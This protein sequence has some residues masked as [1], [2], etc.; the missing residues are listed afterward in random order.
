MDRDH[1]TRIAICKKRREAGKLSSTQVQFCA[2]HEK[3]LWVINARCIW[4]EEE[5]YRYEYVVD[6]SGLIFLSFVPSVLN[7]A[8][9]H[10]IRVSAI[11][12]LL[13]VFQEYTK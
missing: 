13:P 2:D 3:Y 6:L 10:A 8:A 9:V 11:Y 7:Y 4:E 5:A 12:K 1:A